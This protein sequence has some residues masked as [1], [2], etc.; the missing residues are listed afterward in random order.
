MGWRFLVTFRDVI[1]KSWYESVV[2]CL[3]LEIRYVVVA[4]TYK[5]ARPSQEERRDNEGPIKFPG[6]GSYQAG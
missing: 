5:Q 3:K 6:N 4:L 1:N 2:S